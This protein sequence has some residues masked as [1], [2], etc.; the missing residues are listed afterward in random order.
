MELTWLDR[1]IL[2]LFKANPGYTFTVLCLRS[3]LE[4][5]QKD[6]PL[7]KKR[8]FAMREAG[9]LVKDGKMFYRLGD[10][11]K[12]TPSN[13][14]HTPGAPRGPRPDYGHV[15]VSYDIGPF[16][17]PLLPATDPPPVFKY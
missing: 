13:F 11:S 12:I 2:R 4:L 15:Q 14:I 7:L 8:V 9:I 1:Q 3:E 10:T 6:V 17:L 5:P 16:A